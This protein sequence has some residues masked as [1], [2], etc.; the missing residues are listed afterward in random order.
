MLEASDTERGREA[1]GQG[2]VNVADLVTDLGLA[3]METASEGQ[4][5]TDS[6]E[7]AVIPWLLSTLKPARQAHPRHPTQ[8]TTMLT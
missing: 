8:P 2:M 5:G 1:E 3:V 4:G 7:I 6:A